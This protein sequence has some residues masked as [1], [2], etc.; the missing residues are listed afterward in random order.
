M[1]YATLAQA[2]A[3][4]KETDAAITDDDAVVKAALAHVTARIDRVTGR[5]FLP[6]VATRRFDAAGWHLDGGRNALELDQP[7][8]ALTGVTVDGEAW[9]LDTDVLP[10]PRA[11]TPITALRIP[12]SSGRR[13]SGGTDWQDAIAVTGVWGFRTDYADAW[14]GVGETLAAPLSATAASF[15]AA[16]VDGLDSRRRAPRFS[17]GQLVRIDAEYLAVLDT[18][19]GSNTVYVLRGVQGTTAATHAMGAV[20]EAFR[21]EPAIERAAC[22]WAS[23]LYKRRGAFRVTEVDPTTGVSVMFPEDMPGEVANTLA[24][25]TDQ[26]WSV[27]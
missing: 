10:V 1:W 9:A 6:R 24:A 8:M 5:T 2:R 3:E 17:A 7:L 21:V 4:L 25:Y 20:V 22:R 27:V 12:P 11:D 16:D 14:Q 15:V 19:A 18:D 23:Y 13:W 26:R